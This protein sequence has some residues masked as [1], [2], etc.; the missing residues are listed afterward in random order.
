MLPQFVPEVVGVFSVGDVDIHL[1]G[2]AGQFAGSGVGDNADGE[3]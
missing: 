3:V 2:Q 1:A